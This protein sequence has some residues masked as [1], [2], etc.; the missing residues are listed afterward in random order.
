MEYGRASVFH[1]S[2]AADGSQ[3]DSVLARGLLINEKEEYMTNLLTAV[4]TNA[5]VRDRSSLQNLV[6][7]ADVNTPPWSG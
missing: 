7:R 5:R 4:L 2:G 6:H 1:D 3:V